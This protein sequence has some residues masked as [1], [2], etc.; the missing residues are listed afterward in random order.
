MH[1]SFLV[2]WQRREGHIHLSKELVSWRSPKLA[3]GDHFS[4]C[5]RSH[6]NLCWAST[7]WGRCSVPIYVLI[8]PLIHIKEEKHLSMCVHA[9]LTS[10]HMCFAC[11]PHTKAH[12]EHARLRTCT[13][14]ARCNRICEGLSLH[15]T[16]RR[17]PGLIW[18]AVG[19]Q[20]LVFHQHLL[21]TLSKSHCTLCTCLGALLPLEISSAKHTECLS[22]EEEKC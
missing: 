21:T 10:K 12:C 5:G 15:V 16:G 3:A 8:Q 4:N 6:K 17:A 14:A 2:W 20:P 7:A 22:N 18:E 19:S 11:T 1:L 13:L 9:A